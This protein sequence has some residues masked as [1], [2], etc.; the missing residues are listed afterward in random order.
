MGFYV[1]AQHK[2]AH[3]CEVE[4]KVNKNVYNKILKKIAKNTSHGWGIKL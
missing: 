1:T 4:G 3:N 2:T